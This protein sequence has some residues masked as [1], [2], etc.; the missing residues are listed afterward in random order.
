MPLQARLFA[1][2]RW[3]VKLGKTQCEQMFSELPLNA[4][5]LLVQSACLKCHMSGNALFQ[6][7]ARKSEI[8]HPSLCE[9]FAYYLSQSVGIGLRR[10]ESRILAVAAHQVDHARM[11]DRIVPAPFVLSFHIKRLVGVG[12]LSNL[13]QRAGK[14]DKAVMEGRDAVGIQ[15]RCVSARPGA[16]FECANLTRTA[17]A[18]VLFAF[19]KMNTKGD[20]DDFGSEEC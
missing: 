19:P 13:V 8:R 18:F 17:N 12:D 9:T 10:H 6:A 16:V 14:A 15:R 3:G 20:F 7:A 4:D 2:V 1:K 11:I 5:A